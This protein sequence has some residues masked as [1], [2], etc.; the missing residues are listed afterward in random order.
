MPENGV[1]IGPDTTVKART[2]AINGRVKN[3]D[4][5]AALTL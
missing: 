4:F 5:K 2:Q 1:E 3:Q